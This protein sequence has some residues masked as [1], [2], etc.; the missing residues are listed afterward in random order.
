MATDKNTMVGTR[1]EQGRYLKRANDKINPSIYYI[2]TDLNGRIRLND[3]GSFFIEYYQADKWSDV[4]TTQNHFPR[5]REMAIMTTE[6]N[7]DNEEAY[8]M[9]W[10]QKPTER[11]RAYPNRPRRNVGNIAPAMGDNIDDYDDGDVE[12]EIRS[13]RPARRNEYNYNAEFQ[14]ITSLMDGMQRSHAMTLQDQLAEQRNLLQTMNDNLNEAY[15][16]RDE[17]SREIVNVGADIRKEYQA[18][19]EEL[20]RSKNDMSNQMAELVA[21]TREERAAEVQALQIAVAERDG[22]ILSLKEKIKDMQHQQDLTKINYETKVQFDSLKREIKEKESGGLQDMIQMAMQILPSIMSKGGG[23][24]AGGLSMSDAIPQA[25]QQQ[26]NQG[27]LM[28]NV[29]PPPPPMAYRPPP[30]SA[31]V[32]FESAEVETLDDKDAI[33]DDNY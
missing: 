19:I 8:Y 13:I 17:M 5:D 6:I 28:P 7:E 16:S 4:L 27:H 11:S 33:N 25:P 29:A 24:A 32:Q 26:A 22:K 10:S 21:K 23:A 1:I 12:S 31:P 18:Q 9:E 2:V 3:Y 20:I 14:N 30:P 15:R